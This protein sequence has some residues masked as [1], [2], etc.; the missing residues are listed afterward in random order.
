ME[1]CENHSIFSL[2]FY[3]YSL[4]AIFSFHNPVALVCG[5]YVMMLSNRSDS[6]LFEIQFKCLDRLQNNISN[7]WMLPAIWTTSETISETTFE[8]HLNDIQSRPRWS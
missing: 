8:R 1:I 5:G 2:V 4:W 6:V 3:F 7:F